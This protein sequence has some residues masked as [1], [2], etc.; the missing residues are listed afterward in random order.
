MDNF[1][2]DGSAHALRD[3]VLEDLRGRST[4]AE[5]QTKITQRRLG[6]RPKQKTY[7]Y[8][9]APNFVVPIIDDAVREKTDQ[10]VSMLWNAP[11][12]AHAVPL[13]SPI[14]PAAR[15]QVE[16]FFDSYVRYVIRA[17]RKIAQA[18]DQK[19]CHG[20]AVM[21][22]TRK[23]NE[24]LKDTVP[25]LEVLN[26]FDVVVPVDTKDLKNA[27]RITEVLRLSRREFLRRGSER[28]WIGTQE[29][30]EKARRT[31]RAETEHEDDYFDK[32]KDLIGLATSP[33]DDDYI[34]VWVCYHYAQEGNV[35]PE[36]GI[37]EG[38]KMV[39]IFAPDAPEYVL[40]TYPWRDEDIVTLDAQTGTAIIQ[41][42]KE[43]SWPFVQ[44][45]YED[46][47]P[48]Y[49]DQRGGGELCMDDQLE[50]TASKNAKYVLMDYYQNPII[51]GM[52]R[53]QGN[54]R[55]APGTGVESGVDW[56][57]PP[58]IPPN[59]DFSVNDAKANAAKRLGAG[60]MYN[61]TQDMG[62]R[63]LQK[64][65]SEVQLEASRTAG[66]SSA[67]VDLFNEPLAELFQLLWEDLARMGLQF[68]LMNDIGMGASMD[69]A[70]YNLSVAMV[71]ASS[72]K[73]LNPE[74]LLQR[75]M[76]FVEFL[77]SKAQMGVP[78]DMTKCCRDVASQ[79]D[80]RL[81]RDWIIDPQQQGPQGQPPIYDML[82]QINQ[83]LQMLAKGGQDLT[84]RIENVEKLAVSTANELEA[85][86]ARS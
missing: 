52:S 2:I 40:S 43:R 83:N 9:G 30:W 11:R 19:N 76:A 81:T 33:K 77:A 58:P 10:E 38:D 23:Y 73:T 17:R 15:S 78:V 37:E 45:V 62:S 69:P 64:T 84:T 86:D 26:H 71:P 41:R 55:F 61:Y 4:W 28:G 21:K 57:P 46:R 65:A 51:R 12:I 63:K 32:V 60:A 70:L 79:F 6:S 16:L 68:P 35:D 34:V 36:R 22:Q 18:M 5:K 3:T 31:N 24:L 7:P 25:D 74:L 14:P 29:A 39:S 1:A 49:Y 75:Q 82:A 85:A 80:P 56:L 13:G 20:F 42:G 8:K 59:F 50:A 54:I 48:Y 53:N 44:C 72:S 67:A 47:S 27:E 66:L